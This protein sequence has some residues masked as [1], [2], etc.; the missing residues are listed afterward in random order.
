[1]HI[2]I[3]FLFLYYKCHSSFINE[4]T[5]EKNLS[6]CIIESQFISHK[7]LAYFILSASIQFTLILVKMIVALYGEL[8]LVSV[9]VSLSPL[10]VEKFYGCDV[11]ALPVRHSVGQNPCCLNPAH[12]ERGT[13]AILGH[14]HLGCVDG[15]M[16]QNPSM[17]SPERFPPS[18]SSVVRNASNKFIKESS[19]SASALC[20]ISRENGV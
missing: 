3:S 12:L 18:A 2:Y 7:V 16:I 13:H 9:L 20:I 15:C 6:I 4:Q 5:Q 11:N 14:C 8:Y 10:K 1:M 17:L 19:T